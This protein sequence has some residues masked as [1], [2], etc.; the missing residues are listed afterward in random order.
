MILHIG[1]SKAGSSFVQ[2]EILARADAP[3]VIS[4]ESMAFDWIEESAQETSDLKALVLARQYPNAR[5]ILIV[6]SPGEWLESWWRHQTRSLCLAGR[7]PLWK[8][9]QTDFFERCIARHLDWRTVYDDFN[10]RFS[11]IHVLFFRLLRA[12]PAEFTRQFCELC[13]IPV[14]EGVRYRQVNVSRSHAW[15]WVQMWCNRLWWR[16]MPRRWDRAYLYIMKHYVSRIDGIWGR[17]L[18]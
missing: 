8:A 12:D 18:K 5:I 15:C 9:V 16:L 6:R 17:M 4:S 3:H 14:P 2:D 11:D 1:Y 13:E 7:L 10:R